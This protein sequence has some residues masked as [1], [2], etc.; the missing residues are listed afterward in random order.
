GGDARRRKASESMQERSTAC[1]TP[2]HYL[3]A[4]GKASGRL[5]PALLG[6]RLLSALL[7]Q[8][9]PAGGRLGLVFWWLAWWLIVGHLVAG[10]HNP[11]SIL[12][13][14]PGIEPG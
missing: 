3:P 12:E 13:A 9:R 5:L 14:P 1:H 10:L 2:W 4:D 7:I 8:R 11:L 6:R